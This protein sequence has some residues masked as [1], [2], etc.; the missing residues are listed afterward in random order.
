M[1]V[2]VGLDPLIVVSILAEVGL[3]LFPGRQQL[4][5]NCHHSDIGLK[6]DG[7]GTEAVDLPFQEGGSTRL[8]C[9]LRSFLIKALLCPGLS[10][11][12]SPL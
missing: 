9:D 6:G 1:A 11:I 2:V 3:S 5:S 8:I 10:G 12:P 7:W 4:G